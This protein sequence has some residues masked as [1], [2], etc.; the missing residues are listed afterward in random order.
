MTGG[1]S[2]YDIFLCGGSQHFGELER[3]LPKLAPFGRVHLASIT[4]SRAEIEAL[5]PHFDV[6]HEPR[7]HGDGYRNFEHFCIRE[8]NRS[9]V[10]PHFI[11][12]DCDTLLRDDWVEYVDRALEAHPDAVLL[13]PEQG[14]RWIDLALSG[15]LVRAKLG[16]DVAVSNGLKVCGGFYVGQTAF[17]REHDRFMQIVHEFLYCFRDGR[18]SRPSLCPSEWGCDRDGPGS[19]PVVSNYT[20]WGQCSEDHLRCFVV[21]AN[22]AGDRLLH[23]DGGECVKVIRQPGPRHP[24]GSS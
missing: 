11:K 17:F 5:R 24:P 13:G 14:R 19:E 4:L 10:N 18:R 23:L 3:L 7:H 2:K 22:G 16:R 12:L 21:H 8:I 15:P 20:H 9:A 1:R 6:L